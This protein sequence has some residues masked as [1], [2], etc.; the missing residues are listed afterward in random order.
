MPEFL[1]GLVDFTKIIL[2]N[3]KGVTRAAPLQFIGKPAA[4]NNHSQLF[5]ILP[6]LYSFTKKRNKL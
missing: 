2:G 5:K 1:Y 3:N 6:P 4:G